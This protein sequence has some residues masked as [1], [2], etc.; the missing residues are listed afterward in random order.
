MS[1]V[2][3]AVAEVLGVK[4]NAHGSH[5]ALKRLVCKAFGVSLNKRQKRCV[6]HILRTEMSKPNT[7]CVTDGLCA[8]ALL[9]KMYVRAKPDQAGTEYSSYSLQKKQVEQMFVKVVQPFCF[10]QVSRRD[11][12]V[13][14]LV[15]EEAVKGVLRNVF[16]T[17]WVTPDDDCNT[18]VPQSCE[19]SWS[20]LR[21]PS[22]RTCESIEFDPSKPNGLAPAGAA[23]DKQAGSPGSL[24]VVEF[25]LSNPCSGEYGKYNTWTG[26]AAESFAP[27]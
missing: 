9:Q 21:D 23:G 16:C 26:F 25:K 18:F 14:T 7:F 22:I 5:S 8:L 2:T 20:W 13:F 27:V 12:G 6:K 3:V 17:K 4:P 11:P 1:A 15:R 24:A 10:L 19:F